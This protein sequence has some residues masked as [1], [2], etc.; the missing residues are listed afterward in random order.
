MLE[1][2][3]E[4]AERLLDIMEQNGQ[5]DHAVRFKIMGR[6]VEEFQYDFRAIDRRLKEEH[7]VESEQHGLI[8]WLS[9]QDVDDLDGA[10]ISLSAEGGFKIDNPNP[11]WRDGEG[12]EIAQLIEE[13]INPA[14]AMHGGT[15]YLVDIAGDTVYVRMGGG[16][17]GC[18]LRNLTLKGGI[19]KMIRE[20]APHIGQVI[21]VTKHEQGQNPYYTGASRGESPVGA[22]STD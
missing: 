11:V 9:Q 3:P 7:E 4:A 13:K 21:D 19:D 10:V 2:S 22:Q 14:V 16:C 8:I 17:Q 20:V 18:S 15:I 5:H 1:I 12:R 6:G